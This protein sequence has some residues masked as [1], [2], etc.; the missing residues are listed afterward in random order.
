MSDFP[1]TFAGKQYEL[2]L[3]ADGT[4]S[5][6]KTLDGNRVEHEAGSWGYSSDRIMLVLKSTRDTWSWFGMW[7]GN[8][9][10]PIDAN[11]DAIGGRAV[12][13][14]RRTS[15]AVTSA[16][17]VA[18][19]GATRPAS[20]VDPVTL[21][22][23]GAEWILKDLDDKPIRPATR[24]RRPIIL[25]FDTPTGTFTGMSGCNELAGDIAA[26]PRTLTITPRK[27]MRACLADASTER[28]FSS[29]LKETRAY[30]II[31]T[32]LDLLDEHGTRIA[33]F[34]ARIRK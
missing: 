31:G 6:T 26:G 32:T 29:T 24:T 33:R 28:A 18:N 10:R 13:D 23:S 5:A 3:S 27:S 8:V 9:L 12:A 20:N 15:G 4:Y 17:A 30:R 7:P 14:L 22:L 11:G 25:A 2:T 16:G 19:A 34:E 1:A 21:P